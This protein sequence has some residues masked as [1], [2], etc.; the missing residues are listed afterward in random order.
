ML[1]TWESSVLEVLLPPSHKF[2]ARAKAIA[3]I[4]TMLLPPMALAGHRA[5][6]TAPAA[7]G[8]GPA[9]WAAS[10]WGDPVTDAKA[11]DDKGKNKPSLDAGALASVTTAM[12]ARAV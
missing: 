6:P 2:P 7:A 3:L 10:K 8:T 11:K 12:G 4:V 1:L 5:D 9:G